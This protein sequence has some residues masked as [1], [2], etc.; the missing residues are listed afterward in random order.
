MTGAFLLWG[1]GEVAF[2]HP[3]NTRRASITVAVSSLDQMKVLCV[4]PI[5]IALTS[6][7]SEGAAFAFLDA[8]HMRSCSLQC[9]WDNSPCLAAGLE[10]FDVLLP[11]QV[12]TRKAVLRPV[13]S[14]ML[15]R[16][17]AWNGRRC[18]LP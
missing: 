9:V 4:D 5:T 15:S 11:H 13:G 3:G 16:S 18:E 2:S 6:Q 10:P 14:A 12:R 1:M 8:S 7:E 17:V